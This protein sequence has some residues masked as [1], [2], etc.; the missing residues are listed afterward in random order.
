MGI[1]MHVKPRYNTNCFCDSYFMILPR[2]SS[3]W[4]LSFHEKSVGICICYRPTL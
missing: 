4:R 2:S 3:R 1:E